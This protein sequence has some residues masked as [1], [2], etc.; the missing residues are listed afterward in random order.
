MAILKSM[1]TKIIQFI[2]L[3]LLL[4]VSG[5]FWGTWFSLSQSIE[6][7][8]AAEFIHIGKTI[9][10]NVAF[11][12]RIIL[13]LCILCMLISAWWYPAKKTVEFYFGIA[14]IVL[15]LMSLLITLIV[16]VPIDNQIKLWTASNLPAD[17]E[18]IRTKWQFFHG[19]RTLTSIASFACFAIMSIFYAS[20]T[21]ITDSN[22]LTRL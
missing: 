21:S 17:W 9:I 15:I 12:M 4:L 13:P 11:P 7:F 6:N 2:T 5:L 22:S 19:L 16:E 20:V 8:S 18:A 10:S 3:L 14:S 1:E